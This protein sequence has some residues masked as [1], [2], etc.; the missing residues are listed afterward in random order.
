MVSQAYGCPLAPALKDSL[1]KIPEQHAAL[2]LPLEELIWNAVKPKHFFSC[3]LMP[4][5]LA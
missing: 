5:A 2:L 1:G 3:R 4:A